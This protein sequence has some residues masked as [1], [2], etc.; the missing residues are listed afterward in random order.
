MTLIHVEVVF[1]VCGD[2]A[3]IT[4]LLAIVGPLQLVSVAAYTVPYRDPCNLQEHLRSYTET[5]KA[6]I[7]LQGFVR[8]PCRSEFPLVWKCI[9]NKINNCT[10][11][12]FPTFL[13]WKK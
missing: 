5:L 7:S 13:I 6:G 4:F 10:Q 11:N 1:R 9:L 12:V 3:F 8:M 2:D